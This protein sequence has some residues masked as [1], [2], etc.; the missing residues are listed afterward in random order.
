VRRQ[1][2]DRRA[3]QLRLRPA[4]TRL[5]KRV[6]GPFEGVLPTA[7]HALDARTLRRL[8]QDLDKLL[9]VLHPDRKSARIPLASL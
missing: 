8:Q 1:G 3:V 9:D 4:G 6:P 5:L 7:L 2:T